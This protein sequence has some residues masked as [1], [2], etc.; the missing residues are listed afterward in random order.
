VEGETSNIASSS[1]TYIETEHGRLRR[2]QRGIDKKDLQRAKKYGQRKSTH[3]RP[4]GDPAAIY[5]YSDIVYITNEA[6]GEEVTSYAVP[7]LL[8]PVPIGPAMQAQLEVQQNRSPSKSGL[9]DF[10]HCYCC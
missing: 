10:E 3:P 1:L 7:L 2:A 4:N 8:R 5:T 9:V 6:T